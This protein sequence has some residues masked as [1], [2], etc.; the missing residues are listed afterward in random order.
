LTIRKNGMK[1]SLH[2][3]ID[4]SVPERSVEPQHARRAP[5]VRV[6]WTTLGLPIA[7]II[8]IVAF[9]LSSPVFMTAQN[10]RNVGLQ[11][12]A[13]AAVSFGQTFVILT[14]GLDLSVGSAVA[15]VS[16]ITALVGARYGGVAGMAAGVFAGTAVGVANGLAVT[17]F[18]VFPFIA[19]LAMMSIVS[20]L[21][22]NVSSGSAVGD[23]PTTFTD[24]A[25]ERVLGV[26]V[27]L[28]IAIALLILAFVF[29]RYFRLGRHIY[30]VG[31]NLQASKLSGIPVSAVAFMAYV[32]CAFCASIG[33]LIL[34][35]RVASGQPTLGTS[36]PL[37]SVAAVVLG[38]V[39]LFGGRGSI[40]GVAFGVAFIGILSNGLNLLNVSSY[41]QMMVI[42]AALIVA[43][44]F[45]QRL[46]Q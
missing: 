12:A 38:G 25:I 4:E 8:M 13:L 3:S 9:S 31:G 14:G 26:P 37:Q 34:T 30:A 22:L 46:R 7:V 36:L 20:G 45:D 39:S 11:A 27:P 19:T 5:R 17:W 16:V 40:I 10:M 24:L 42:G 28:L 43:V 1:P 21:A 18:R 44:T 29:L 41:T 35:A 2:I 33:G 23:V 15:L 32:L 6:H